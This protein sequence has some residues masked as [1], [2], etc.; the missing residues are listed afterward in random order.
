M[1]TNEKQEIKAT[2]GG[3]MIYEFYYN[4]NQNTTCS[5][6]L[7]IWKQDLTTQSKIFLNDSF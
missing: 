4:Q 2:C 1:I 3:I 5:F 6:G 7:F